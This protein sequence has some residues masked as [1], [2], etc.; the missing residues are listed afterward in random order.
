M[1]RLR[2]VLSAA[3]LLALAAPAA[4]HAQAADIEGVW[5]FSGGQVAVQGQSDGSFTGTVIRTTTL[6]NCPHPVGEQ[7]WLGVV[8]HDS[9]SGKVYAA[10]ALWVASP[11]KS[12]LTRVDAKTNQVTDTIPVGPMPRFI[13]TGAGACASAIVC[14]GST[15]ACVHRCPLRR[16]HS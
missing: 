11:E 16:R 2:A 4:A 13:T 10:G 5:T 6:A 12:V 1:P 8:R 15:C 7:M 14:A 9:L 3:C